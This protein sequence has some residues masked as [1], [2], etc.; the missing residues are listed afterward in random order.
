MMNG[1]IDQNRCALG[2]GE[3]GRKR[4]LRASATSGADVNGPSG[5][6]ATERPAHQT[7]YAL[8]WDAPSKRVWGPRHDAPPLVDKGPRHLNRRGSVT[9]VIVEVAA[10]HSGT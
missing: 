1:R 2:C 5:K 8:R 7:C 3:P 10:F 9:S 4:R 6:R